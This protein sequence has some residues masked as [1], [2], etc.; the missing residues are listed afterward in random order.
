[1]STV[2]T[3][4]S[5]TPAA[6][7]TVV[8]APKTSTT[9]PVKE[10]SDGTNIDWA[11]LIEESVNA[12]LAK[13]TSIDLKID[14]N[15][16]K[17]AAYQD[18]KNLLSSLQTAANALRAPSGSTARSTDAF[19]SRSAYLTANGNVNAASVFSATVDPAADQG[20]YKLEVVQLATAHK[21]SSGTVA[22]KTS[23]LNITSVIS[24]GVEGGTPS[25]LSITAD[26]SLMEISEAINKTKASSG[27]QASIVQVT[28]NDF[29]LILTATETGKSITSE[30]LSGDDALGAL[31]LTNPAG[32][33]ATVLQ[34]AQQAIVRV[35]D[36]EVTRSSNE[37]SDIITGT[38][39]YLYQA[40]PPGTSITLEVDAN[41]NNVK[42]AILQLVEAYN[43]YR[44]FA[45]KQQTLPSRTYDPPLFGDGTMRSVN[46]SIGDALATAIGSESMSLLGLTYDNQ[47]KLVIEEDKLDNI[48]LTNLSAVQ[49]LLS[50]GM[51]TSN[52]NIQLLARGSSLPP[53]FTLDI[54]TDVNG[55]LT[56]ATVN[57]QTGLF[58]VSGAR[59][60]GAAGTAYEGISLVYTGTSPAA[61]DL[62]FKTGIAEKLFNAA[63]GATS[64]SGS[65]T[66]LINN[67]SS[68][69][70]EMTKRSDNIRSQAEAYR[71]TI[72]MRYARYQAAIAQADSMK[73]YLST[74]LDT[75]NAKS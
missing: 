55:V 43:A 14:A 29:R 42:T 54:E 12:K 30:V 7:T 25:T 34:D 19:L 46:A 65:L 71:T 27:V 15:D 51:T 2:S 37:I 36:L 66:L 57:G 38:T 16:L 23:D 20:T 26:M 4:S 33:F 9:K 39:L 50:F 75:W 24:L 17:M 59:L 22:T 48:L 10:P 18:A 31:G 41:V 45:V 67:L 58:T 63:N 47:N 68:Q 5:A 53:D 3:T 64:G 56:G 6:T 73:D 61:V 49:N 69:S 13:A 11:G 28:P 44:D 60:V 40:T 72:S 62:S 32:D 1:M 35:D 21:I 70:T 74:L 8:A 52:T